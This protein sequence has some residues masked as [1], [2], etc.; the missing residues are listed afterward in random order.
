MARAARDV[1]LVKRVH[2]ALLAL[3]I[4]VLALALLLRVA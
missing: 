4:A 2:L 3:G 1:R